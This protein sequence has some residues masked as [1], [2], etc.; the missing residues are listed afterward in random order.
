MKSPQL[1]TVAA[2]LFALVTAHQA[3]AFDLVSPEEGSKCIVGIAQI[4]CV[5]GAKAGEEIVVEITVGDIVIASAKTVAIASDTWGVSIKRPPA[6][7]MLGQAVVT[8][9]VG[10]EKVSRKIHFVPK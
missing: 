8:A 2:L 10:K 6:G 4:G 9:K 3:L 7:W 1:R 5:G